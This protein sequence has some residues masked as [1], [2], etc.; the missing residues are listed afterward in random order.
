MQNITYSLSSYERYCSS[1]ERPLL[2]LLF[3]E[4][5]KQ[6]LSFVNN[7]V[8]PENDPVLS[9]ISVPA[10]IV[11]WNAELFYGPTCEEFVAEWPDAPFPEPEEV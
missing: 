4:M 3:C 8:V 2:S 10:L 1:C 5:Q 11:L 7:P 6:N 9:L